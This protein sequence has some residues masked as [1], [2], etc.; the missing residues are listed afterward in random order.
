MNLYR[1]FTVF[2]GLLIAA[3]TVILNAHGY[4][5][6]FWLR[7][8]TTTAAAAPEIVPPIDRPELRALFSADDLNQTRYVEVT[9]IIPPDALLQ[10]Q[11]TTPDPALLPLYAAARAP[12]RLIPYCDEVVRSIGT[13][14]DVLHTHTHETR[15]GKLALTGQL[16]FLPDFDMGSPFD[17]E[18]GAITEVSV[19]LPHSGDLLPPNEADTRVAGM[20]QAAAICAAL[21]DAYGNCVLTGVMFKVEEL[22]ITDLEALPA[23]TNPQRLAVEARFA[24]FAAPGAL[25]EDRLQQHIQTL[26]DPA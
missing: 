25:D 13:L 17:M 8:D 14:C 9:E 19:A 1:I 26:R 20:Q 12:A 16:A 6:A 22:W 21:K 4:D 7:D 5:I 2:F 15:E 11:E 18:D 10:P 3:P 23:G 24:V